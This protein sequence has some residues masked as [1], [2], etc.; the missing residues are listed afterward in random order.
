MR[1]FRA[2][3]IG[4][5]GACLAL[6]TGCQPKAPQVVEALALGAKGDGISDDTAAIQ[7]AIDRCAAKGGG[8]VILGG[9]K[10]YVSGTLWLKSKINLHI[11]EGS[12]LLAST[13]RE[14]YPKD[15]STCLIMAED[16][17]DVS[18][19]GGGI[20]NGRGKLFM[21]EETPDIYK[22]KSWRPGLFSLLKCKG[23][24]LR[25]LTLL[26]SAHWAVHL[27]GCQDVE[28]RRLTIRNDP[29]IPNCDGIDPDH[30][31]DVYITDCDIVAGD[32][33]IVI[34]NTRKYADLGPSER[35]VVDRCGLQSTSAALKIGTESWNDFRAI[36]FSNCRIRNSNRGLA[37]QLRDPGNIEDVS[38]SDITVQTRLYADPWWGK[39]EPIHISVLSR[40]PGTKVGTLRNV[41][42]S[43]IK[44][45]GENGIYISGSPDSR[46]EGIVLD[47]VRL[48]VDKLTDLDGG[49]HDL[50]PSPG[51]GVVSHQT[52]GVFLQQLKDVTLKDCQVKWG[53]N[54]PEYFGPALEAHA[55]EGLK[56]ENFQGE[57]AHPE[58]GKAQI[59]T[60]TAE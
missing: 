9:G 30:C 33:C 6:A 47:K 55:V 43:N 34:K 32:D 16:A 17:R 42:F 8:A 39:A 10:T 51:K 18:V 14:A 41:R 49:K 19:T 54:R 29:R 12:T 24:V 4:L 59:I 53:F 20:I 44:A 50:R 38:F 26:D 36:R 46:P 45:L 60:E 25:D 58:Q 1:S 48:T 57:A 22:P 5:L 23:V 35:I 15:G 56:L 31:R 37:I 27:I 52:A 40:T 2:A 13:D 7:R 21:A 11:E 28:I 3:W